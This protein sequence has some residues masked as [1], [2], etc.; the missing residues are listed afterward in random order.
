M[1]LNTFLLEFSKPG[2]RE[3]NQVAKSQPEEGTGFSELFIV[4]PPVESVEDLLAD[5]D[6]VLEPLHCLGQTFIYQACFVQ[7]VPGIEK[8]AR[9]KFIAL[10]EMLFN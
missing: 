8:Q 7:G 3:V 10:A 9:L 2:I 5:T 6:H 4:C 1:F